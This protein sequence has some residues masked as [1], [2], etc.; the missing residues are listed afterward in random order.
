VAAVSGLRRAAELGL[1]RGAVA[2]LLAGRL[3]ELLPVTDPLTLPRPAVPVLLAHGTAD[4]QV[5]PELSGA[6]AA[7]HGARL[8]PLP[9]VGH[10]APF[11]PGTWACSWLLAELMVAV[12]RA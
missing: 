8:V 9:G 12:S 3:A 7:R 10:Y 4:G 11:V 6:Y 5:P 1:G 2:E